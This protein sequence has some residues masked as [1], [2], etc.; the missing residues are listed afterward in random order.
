MWNAPSVGRPALGPA[1]KVGVFVGVAFGSLLFVA[2]CA[3]FA[4]AFAGASPPNPCA[5]A[6]CANGGICIDLG[7]GAF[8]CVCVYG[9]LG[10]LCQNPGCAATVSAQIQYL[11]NQSVLSGIVDQPVFVLPFLNG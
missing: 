2:A 3:V 1:G 10:S 6:P 9:F 5:S 11:G 4:I 7:G 8:E